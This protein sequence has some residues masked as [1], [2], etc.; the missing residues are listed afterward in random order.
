M[1]LTNRD[2]SVKSVYSYNTPERQ[3]KEGRE[4]WREEEGREN[5]GTTTVLSISI[6]FT[7]RGMGLPSQGWIFLPGDEE[8]A[9]NKTNKNTKETESIYQV[10]LARDHKNEN[11]QVEQMYQNK[12][13]ALNRCVSTVTSLHCFPGYKQAQSPSDCELQSNKFL[14]LTDLSSCLCIGG[15]RSFITH[16]NSGIKQQSLFYSKRRSYINVLNCIY[17]L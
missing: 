17:H 16:L 10:F 13:I 4:E 15:V 6:Y 2:D 1:C 14:L 9:E 12:E 7:L 3:K 5:K 11:V 8:K